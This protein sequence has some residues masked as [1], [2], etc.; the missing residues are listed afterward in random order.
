MKRRTGY[1]L[2]EVVVV[3]LILGIGA[4]VVAPAI[5]RGPADDLDTG[6]DEIIRVL[7]TARR[8][9][10]NRATSVQVRLDMTAARFAIR[11]VQSDS[12]E[13]LAEGTLPLP[14][15]VAPER[16]DAPV[17]FTF[18]PTGVATASDS[19]RLTGQ[20]GSRVIAADRWTGAPVRGRDDS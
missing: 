6:S 9:A 13:L 11:S 17:E 7:E 14:A 3:L 10:V 20:S 5:V 18:A 8:E 12:I 16:R 15:G 4:A 1:T 19:V 2:A